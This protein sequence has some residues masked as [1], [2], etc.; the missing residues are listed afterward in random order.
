MTRAATGVESIHGLFDPRRPEVT[1]QMDSQP[2][3]K[4]R[5][6]IGKDENQ[7]T[8]RAG[9]LQRDDKLTFRFPWADTLPPNSVLPVPNHREAVLPVF[10]ITFKGDKAKGLTLKTGDVVKFWE[11]EVLKTGYI[12]KLVWEPNRYPPSF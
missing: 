8:A 9:A 2:Y 10:T 1:D 11:K 3:A 5:F 6:T 4:R 7:S 12:L